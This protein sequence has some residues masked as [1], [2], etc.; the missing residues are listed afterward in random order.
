MTEQHGETTTKALAKFEGKL[1]LAMPELQE[2]INLI[3]P[4]APAEAVM[5]LAIICR[6]FGLHPLMNQIWLVP[7]RSKVRGTKDQWEDKWAVIQGIRATRLLAARKKKFSYVDNTP[8]VMNEEE[9]IIKFG[10]VYTDRV[11]H[12]TKLRDVDGIQVS[13]VGFYLHTEK[14]P[15]GL[16]KGNTRGNMANIRSERQAIDR[17]VPDTIPAGIEVI[18]ERYLSV[19]VSDVAPVAEITETATKEREVDPRTGEIKEKVEKVEGA[20]EDQAAKDTDELWPGEDKGKTKEPPTE[21]PAASLK[22]DI[23]W[24]NGEL[25]MLELKPDIVNAWVSQAFNVYAGKELKDTLAKLTVKQQEVFTKQVNDG[26][27]ALRKGNG[28]ATSQA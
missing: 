23:P 22:I 11:A 6:D 25:A 7:Y 8:R 10:E 18:D 2:V 3:N 24:L 12:I 5:R 4:E 1:H 15:K 27:P 14:D 13:G 9:Q 21:T 17:L 16:E 26:L 20:V 19:S 28:K